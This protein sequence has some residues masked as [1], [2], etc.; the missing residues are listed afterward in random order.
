M[1]DMIP[2]AVT[3]HDPRN[4]VNAARLEKALNKLLELP[5]DDVPNAIREQVRQFKI[6]IQ[7]ENQ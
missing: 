7:E 2:I 6:A 4:A 3:P 5:T 1:K